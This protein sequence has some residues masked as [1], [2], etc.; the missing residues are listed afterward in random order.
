M[1]DPQTW[2]VAV[3]ACVLI[4]AVWA[5]G[6]VREDAAV[7]RAH[8]SGIEAGRALERSAARGAIVAGTTTAADG[9]Q[10]DSLPPRRPDSRADGQSI[11]PAPSTLSAGGDV[12]QPD[13]TARREI[14]AWLRAPGGSEG[15][16]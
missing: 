16:D 6:I 8:A 4:A 7:V 15:R 3:A 2:L 12:G 10:C 11:D 1:I 13:A 9:P 14:P 5:W